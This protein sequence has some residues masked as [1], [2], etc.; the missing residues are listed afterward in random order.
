M[1]NARVKIMAERENEKLHGEY[2][3]E[4]RLNPSPLKQKYSG[5]PPPCHAHYHCSH[6][7]QHQFNRFESCQAQPLSFSKLAELD[8]KI[9]TVCNDVKALKEHLES[10][11][12]QGIAAADSNK[13]LST[14]PDRM[15]QSK[16]Q[17]IM[18]KFLLLLSFFCPIII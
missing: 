18:K 12:D 10:I 9:A 5:C 4:E 16:L 13:K 1:L 8:Q 7:C 6:Q 2:F 11:H 3:P 15:E 14:P 17:I